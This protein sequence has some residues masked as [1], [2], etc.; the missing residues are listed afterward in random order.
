MHTSLV[1]LETVGPSSSAEL[2]TQPLRSLKGQ[3]KSGMCIPNLSGSSN[4]ERRC[5]N[6]SIK[7]SG[8]YA[9]DQDRTSL[10]V[11]EFK[12]SQSLVKRRVIPATDPNE[13]I[14]GTIMNMKSSL[15]GVLQPQ[16]A[17]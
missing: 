6:N 1:L 5:L 2:G 17:S 3:E 10:Q 9:S 7:F 13:N 12:S 11:S 15:Y 8:D 14:I 16:E 4:N